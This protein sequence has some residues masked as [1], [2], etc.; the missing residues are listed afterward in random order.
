MK[1]IPNRQKRIVNARESRQKNRLTPRNIRPDKKEITLR[2]KNVKP[3]A[4]TE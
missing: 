2:Q 3:P 4:F 1:G